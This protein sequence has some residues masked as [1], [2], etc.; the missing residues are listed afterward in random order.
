MFITFF[1]F[2]FICIQLLFTHSRWHKCNVVHVSIDPPLDS[3]TAQHHLF[4]KR[5]Y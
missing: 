3:R 4:I 2:A 5:H 1:V